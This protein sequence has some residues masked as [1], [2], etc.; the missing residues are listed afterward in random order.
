MRA[1]ELANVF[2]MHV[3]C[4]LYLNSTV[5]SLRDLH[6]QE[7]LSKASVAHSKGMIVPVCLMPEP[8]SY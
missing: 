4:I 3:R 2:V 5:G 6:A 8:V 7:V 1:V